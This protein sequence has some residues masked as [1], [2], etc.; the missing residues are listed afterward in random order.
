MND[1]DLICLELYIYINILSYH[2]KFIVV[3]YVSQAS[4]TD[5]PLVENVLT[6]ER[7]VG[8]EPQ[9]VLTEE[10]VAVFSKQWRTNATIFRLALQ[11]A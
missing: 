3:W 7:N 4:L 2:T 8:F 6:A 9:L 10:R 11:E 5:K 1:R